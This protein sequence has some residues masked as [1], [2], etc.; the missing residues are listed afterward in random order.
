MKL[1]IRADQTGGILKRGWIVG[2]LA[3][4][5]GCPAVSGVDNVR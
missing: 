1:I 4:P 2:S 5:S 3:I